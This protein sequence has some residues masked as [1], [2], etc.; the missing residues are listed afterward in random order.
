MM[1]IK[2][3]KT[4]V[5]KDDDEDDKGDDKEEEEDDDDDK[6]D[7][8]GDDDDK[9]DDD[10]YY[11]IPNLL[12]Q[13]QKF[14]T[15]TTSIRQQH[16]TTSIH[17]QHIISVCVINESIRQSVSWECDSLSGDQEIHLLLPNEAFHQL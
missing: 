16:I 17:Q 10:D 2:T 12:F 14:T 4:L 6:D 11:F 5:K 7:K 8:G 3:M 13:L 9:D 15:V 1:M